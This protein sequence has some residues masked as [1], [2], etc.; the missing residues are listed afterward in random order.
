MSSR[1]LRRRQEQI[2]ILD[3]L[4]FPNEDASDSDDKNN[5]VQDGGKRGKK[6]K[7]AVANLFELV[8]NLYTCVKFVCFLSYS[9]TF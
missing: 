6:N 4:A 7:K 9:I 1:A 8:C 3:P 2:G 5:L